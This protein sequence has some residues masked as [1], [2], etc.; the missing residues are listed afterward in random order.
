ML[1]FMANSIVATPNSY[2]PQVMSY[3][4]FSI[5]YMFQNFSKSLFFTFSRGPTGPPKKKRKNANE[6][7][8][9]ALNLS[10]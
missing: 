4:D 3:I 8:E 2:L 9:N 7:R 10:V 5:L 1:L 6:N